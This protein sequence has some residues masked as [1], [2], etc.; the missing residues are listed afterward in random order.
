MKRTKPVMQM[1]KTNFE[2]TS[3]FNDILGQGVSSK[4]GFP[5]L[6]QC[7][8]R[9]KL[10]REEAVDEMTKEMDARNLIGVA[11]AIGDA[12]V[13]VYGAANDFGLDAD[14]IF[15]EIHRSNMS[16][17]CDNEEDAKYAVERYA[18]GDGYHGKNTPIAAAYR[19]CSHPDFAGKF[20]VYQV[21]DGKTLKG[22]S[23]SEPNLEPIVYGASGKPQHPYEELLV[24]ADLKMGGEEN[25]LFKEKLDLLAGM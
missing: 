7:R 11:D 20:I 1:P 12:L 13:V 16:K 8:L 10:I 18:A 6:S 5:T 22:P 19:P 17:L 4:V 21:E 14:V 23:Y 3:E 2:M 9:A 15:A 24:L 25:W